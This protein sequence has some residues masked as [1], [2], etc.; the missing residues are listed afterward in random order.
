MPPPLSKARGVGWSE[1]DVAKST[2]RKT[3]VTTVSVDDFIEA[4]PSEQVRDDCRTLVSL[5]EQATGAPAEMWGSSIV[6]FGRYPCLMASGTTIER[7]VRAR[8]R[9]SNWPPNST[10]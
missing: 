7:R 6:G 1:G 9:C 5:M 4:Q 2:E 3:K 8:V 10:W